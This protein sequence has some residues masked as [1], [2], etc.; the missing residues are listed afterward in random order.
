M[1]DFF[2]VSLISVGVPRQS[3]GR[4]LANWIHI[5]WLLRERFNVTEGK[6][7]D[8]SLSRSLALSLAHT[9]IG[10]YRGRLGGRV[11]GGAITSPGLAAGVWVAVDF[12]VG[13]AGGWGGFRERGNVKSVSSSSSLDQS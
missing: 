2:Q 11:E 1:Q 8:N 3:G 13:G 12:V 9:L 10:T 7:M 4:A 6:L 5:S